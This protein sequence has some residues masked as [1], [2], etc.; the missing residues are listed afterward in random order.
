MAEASVSRGKG[1][2]TR[3]GECGKATGGWDA[4]SYSLSKSLDR[5]VISIRA[6]YCFLEV[7]WM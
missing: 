1:S 7:A 6:L 3:A 2:V 5:A 4:G